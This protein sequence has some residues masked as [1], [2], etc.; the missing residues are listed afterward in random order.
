MDD[1]SAVEGTDSAIL[2]TKIKA[3]NKINGDDDEKEKGNLV[4]LCILVFEL[5]FILSYL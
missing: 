3:N 1:E 4:L 2:I 5:C